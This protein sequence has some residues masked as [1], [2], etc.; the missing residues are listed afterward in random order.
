MNQQPRRNEDRFRY[1]MHRVTAVIDDDAHLDR[2][3]HDLQQ[4][5][6]DLTGVNVLSGPDGARL[7]D[8]T[9]TGH[10][11]RARLLRL[12]QWGAYEADALEAH[13]RALSDRR[14][15]VYVPAHGEEQR[16]RAVAVL[17][18]AGGMILCTSVGGAS[19]N[20]RARPCGR[21]RPARP[22]AWVIRGRATGSDRVPAGQLRASSSTI[23]DSWRHTPSMAAR[24]KCPRVCSRR[25]PR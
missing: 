4:A 10:G 19:N 6:V 23:N 13:D 1:P 14:H 16:A 17:Q 7:L 8:R 15:V 11:L 22:L 20:S 3:L 25:T 12:A 2:A 5:G 24:T 18:A 9:G 21:R